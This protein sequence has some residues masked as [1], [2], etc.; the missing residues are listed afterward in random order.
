M[1]LIIYSPDVRLNDVLGDVLLRQGADTATLS[2]HRLAAYGRVTHEIKKEVMK[3]V[4]KQDIKAVG[5][6]NPDIGVVSH[7]DDR[8]ILKPSRT[9]AKDMKRPSQHVTDVRARDIFGPGW[10]KKLPVAYA[11]KLDQVIEQLE[12]TP[13]GGKA[14]DNPDTVVII[15]RTAQD[16]WKALVVDAGQERLDERLF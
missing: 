12:M 10:S 6:N 4:T 1:N 9:R 5:C 14:L 13:G 16:G 11:D 2:V 8:I 3:R 7:N 15:V